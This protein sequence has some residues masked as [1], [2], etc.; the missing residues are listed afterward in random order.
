MKGFVAL[1]VKETLGL[2][3]NWVG[4]LVLMLVLGSTQLLDASLTLAPVSGRFTGGGEGGLVVFLLAFVCGHGALGPEFTGRH[5]EFLDGLPVRRGTVYVAKL[6]A[7][8]LPSVGMLGLSLTIDLVASWW[9]PGAPGAS[10]YMGI[11]ALHALMLIAAWSGFTIGLLLSWF[12]RLAWGVVLL[13]LI[14]SGV[15]SVLIAPMRPYV[16]GFG[17]FGS[18]TFVSREMTHPVGPIVFWIVIGWVQAAL[19]GIL[20]IGP[21]ERLTLR[22]SMG[23]GLV[24]W[25]TIGCGSL[26]IGLFAVLSALGLLIRAS[27]L[28][29]PIEVE[30]TEHFRLLFHAEHGDAVRAA[31]EDVEALSTSIGEMVGNPEPVVMDLEF[32]GAQANHAGL[33]TGG[34]IRLQQDAARDVVAHELVHAHAFAVS[35][36]AAWHQKEHTRFFDEGL[37]SWVTAVLVDEPTVPPAAAAIHQVDPVMFDLLVED[38][39]WTAERDMAAAYPLGVVFLEALDGHGGV[40]TRRCTLEQIAEAGRQD[41]AGLALWVGIGQRCGFDLDAVVRDFETLLEEAADDLPPLPALEARLDGRELVVVDREG[42]GFQVVCRFRSSVQQ[43]VTQYEHVWT[44][45][46]RCALPM[47]QLSEPTFDY[48]VGFQFAGET[49]FDAWVTAPRP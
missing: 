3:P 6:I 9:S 11:L 32:L 8:W 4:M 17:T 33:F 37:A 28:L 49:V 24:R 26:F 42:R 41:I 39:R 15:F 18:L 20:F 31:T 13:G 19:A 38:A 47:L 23:T 1:L 12:G 14:M 5:I 45:D 10:P 25:A 29:R 44:K 2:L 40:E 43:D 21:G 22:G 36:P 34:K 48:Q 7:A 30:S 35:G 27:D 16:P 46:G